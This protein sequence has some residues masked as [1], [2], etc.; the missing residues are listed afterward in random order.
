[1]QAPGAF[2]ESRLSRIR[3]PEY[4]LWALNKEGNPLQSK[5]VLQLKISV[6][7]K[8]AHI[9]CSEI[10]VVFVNDV[11]DGPENLISSAKLTWP[12]EFNFAT[13]AKTS[14]IR[15][16]LYPRG[17]VNILH[18][19]TFRSHGLLN[20]FPQTQTDAATC[21]MHMLCGFL[22]LSERAWFWANPIFGLTTSVKH[23]Q[24]KL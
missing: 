11:P 10:R 8:R 4:I 17:C 24:R 22:H 21:I 3:I 7:Y 19:V 9:C 13:Y 1:M 12:I 16:K 2:Q 5:R 15:C 6:L 23:H 18:C 14:G 20:S